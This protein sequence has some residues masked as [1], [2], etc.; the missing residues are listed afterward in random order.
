M[1]D[2]IY[3]KK[4]I[5]WRYMVIFKDGP[6]DNDYRNM[7]EEASQIGMNEFDYKKERKKVLTH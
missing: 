1:I 5:R 6:E 2:Y 7:I 3:K 4:R